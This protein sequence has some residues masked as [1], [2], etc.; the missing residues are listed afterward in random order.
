MML[1]DKTRQQVFFLYWLICSIFI[2]LFL[3]SGSIYAADIKV[4]IDRT[5]I[6]LNETFTL[7]F[8]ASDDVDDDPDFSPLEKDF[9]IL[10]KSTSSNIS[11]I[12]GQYQKTCAGAFP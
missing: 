6:E 1:F 9:R 8:E 12:N 2:L 7:H 11:I 4:Q 3:Y 5:Q 10:N